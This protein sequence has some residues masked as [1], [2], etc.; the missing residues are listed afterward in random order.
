MEM[1]ASET[2]CQ[3][4]S[5]QDERSTQPTDEEMAASTM[6][7]PPDVMSAKA[8]SPI[9]HATGVKGLWFAGGEHALLQ[10]AQALGRAWIHVREPDTELPLN[11]DD[12]P[13][14]FGPYRKM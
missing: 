5:M 4:I 13:R 8:T 14:S 11:D 12:F 7:P 9:A 3:S 6:P 1:V 10:L 2:S